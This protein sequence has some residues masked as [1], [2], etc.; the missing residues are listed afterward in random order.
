MPTEKVH[1]VVHLEATHSRIDTPQ[2]FKVK[3]PHGH[4]RHAIGRSVS[5]ACLATAVGVI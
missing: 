2:A 5:M 3:I 1:K 4:E